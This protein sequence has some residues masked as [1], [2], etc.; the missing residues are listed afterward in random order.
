MKPDFG[1]DAPGLVRTFFLVG[2]GGAVCAALIFWLLET[3]FPWGLIALSLPLLVTFYALGMGSFMIYGSKIMKT[4]DSERLLDRLQWTGNEMVLDVRCGRGLMLIGAA[5]R[6]KAGK[7]IGVDIWQASDQS[8][9]SDAGAAGNARLVGVADR[10]E[11]KTADMRS[12]PFEDRAGPE[13]L[14]KGLSGFSA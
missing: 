6:L 2:L 11:V 1:I 3:G 7:A 4:N 10:V 8:A 12:L 5:K 14:N 9:N 13:N